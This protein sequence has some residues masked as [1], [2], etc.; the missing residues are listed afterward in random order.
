[1]QRN[2]AARREYGCQ[3]ENVFDIVAAAKSDPGESS[4][5][6]ETVSRSE[7]GG[8]QSTSEEMA[9]DGRRDTFCKVLCRKGQNY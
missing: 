4:G 7:R 3:R 9:L 1:M 8:I 5:T 6:M 2:E